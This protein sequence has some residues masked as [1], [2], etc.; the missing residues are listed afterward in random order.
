MIMEV[1]IYVY[2]NIKSSSVLMIYANKHAWMYVDDLSS[3]SLI[4]AHE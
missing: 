3:M 4:N 2:L 1:Y